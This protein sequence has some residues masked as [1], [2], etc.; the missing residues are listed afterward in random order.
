MSRFE[1][2]VLGFCILW[3]VVAIVGTVYAIV[4]AVQQYYS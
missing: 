3:G 4:I 1:K 2:F